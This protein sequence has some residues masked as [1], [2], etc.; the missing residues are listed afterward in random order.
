[1]SV[2]TKLAD[3]LDQKHVSYVTLPHP[4]AYTAQEIAAAVHVPGWEVAKS[5]IVRADG[6]FV[7]AV[8]PATRRI[9]L[10]QLKQALGASLIR[11]AT[12]AEFAELFPECEIGAMPPFGNLYQV[13][14]VVDKSLK[15]DKEIVFNAG[16]HTETIR[17]A[18]E[19]FTGL[20]QPLFAS[21]TD[22]PI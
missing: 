8:L 1:M 15:K 7:M 21:F 19:E 6:R 9:D 13:P 2:S 4:R 17:M 18:F 12:E 10:D 11:L 22:K 20:V 3:F 16:T 5:V 14:V